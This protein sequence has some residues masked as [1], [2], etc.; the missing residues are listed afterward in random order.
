MTNLEANADHNIFGSSS[1]RSTRLA[2]MNLRARRRSEG[3]YTLVALLAL[4][5]VVA[6]FAMAVAPSM[7]QQTQRDREQEAIYRGEQVADAIAQY[8]IY[9]SR[10][11]GNFGYQSLP[12]S[13][14]Q[15]LEGIPLVG[16]AKN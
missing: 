3:G 10:A 9:K 2:E 13:M 1:M 11:T 16:G 12:S 7:Q 8:Y 6:L 15:L 14:D 5:T 4:M